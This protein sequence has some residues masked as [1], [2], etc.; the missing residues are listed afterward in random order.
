MTTIK[1]YG[2]GS[3]TSVEPVKIKQDTKTVP[4]PIIKKDTLSLMRDVYSKLKTIEKD[5]C[6]IYESESGDECFID[7]INDEVEYCP[8]YDIG[9]GFCTIRDMITDIDYYLKCQKDN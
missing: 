4:R 5:I 3:K 2:R 1:F 8:F 7:I 6:R 9:E